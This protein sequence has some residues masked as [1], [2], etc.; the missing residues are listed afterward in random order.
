MDEKK[1]YILKLLPDEKFVCWIN[2][3]Q[4]SDIGFFPKDLRIECCSHFAFLT[5]GQD[6][7]QGKLSKNQI[8]L[9]LMDP[10][11]IETNLAHFKSSSFYDNGIFDN[12]DTIIKSCI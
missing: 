8:N 2:F 4:F 6:K 9:I 10:F 11:Y 1:K 7:S 3:N 5:T 12:C